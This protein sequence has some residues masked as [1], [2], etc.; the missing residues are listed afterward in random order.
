MRTDALKIPPTVTII[1]ALCLASGNVALAQP[2]EEELKQRILAQAQS[3]SP[4]DYAFTRTI[5]TEQVSGGK[6]EKKVSVERFDPTKPAGE[7]WTLVSMD[8]AAPAPDA[9]K[10]FRTEAAK[11]R[12]VPGY[13]RL[14]GY[15][16]TPATASTDARDRTVFR[17][18]AL[19][20]GT[21]MVLDSDVSQNATV[22]ASV[23]EA[24]GVPFAEQIHVTVKP[25]RLKLIMKLEKYESISR[26]RIGP[27]GKPLLT[28]QTSDMSGGGMGMEGRA[29][30]VA[31][32]SDYQLVS[33]RR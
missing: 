8:G 22:D 24:N 28:E 30:T 9:L 20:K 19:P 10:H 33:K 7:R 29:R 31:T 27:E 16:G 17:F 13:A 11:R 25:M 12:V 18:S 5:R 4:D 3:V 1:A 23:D 14:A 32:Y 26:Y 2:K 21:L 6:T 15:F